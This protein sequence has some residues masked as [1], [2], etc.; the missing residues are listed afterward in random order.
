L[1]GSVT[2]KVLHDSEIPVWTGAHLE[3]KPEREFAVK[4]VLCALDLTAHSAA[5][6][7]RAAALAE[8]FGAQLKFVHV[9]PGPRVDGP[10]PDGEA[11]PEWKQALAI[12]TA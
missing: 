9:I 11:F 4:T 2:A 5:T 6:A 7:S 8:K 1:I 10:G 12:S 3:E